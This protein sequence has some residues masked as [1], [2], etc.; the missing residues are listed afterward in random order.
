MG[1]SL[2]SKRQMHLRRE[3]GQQC[4][5]MTLQTGAK[6]PPTDIADNLPTRS[7]PHGASAAPKAPQCRHE[8]AVCQFNPLADPPCKAGPAGDLKWSRQRPGGRW[9]GKS[10]EADSSPPGFLCNSFP[11]RPQLTGVIATET[12]DHRQGRKGV[13]DTLRELAHTIEQHTQRESPGLP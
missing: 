1:G 9:M 10:G 4:D 6:S 5:W 13:K 3:L 2:T 8:A 11:P 12:P 7:S